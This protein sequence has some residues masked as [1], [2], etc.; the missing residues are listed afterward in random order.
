MNRFTSF[1]LTG[2]LCVRLTVLAAIVNAAG[3]TVKEAH[4][5]SIEKTANQ[6]KR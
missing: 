2:L 1:H 3:T 5:R 4:P 6:Q